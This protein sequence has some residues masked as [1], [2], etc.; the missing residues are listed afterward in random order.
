MFESLYL[1]P[2]Y[3]PDWPDEAGMIPIVS[4]RLFVLYFVRSQFTMINMI[5]N[6]FLIDCSVTV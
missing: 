4:Q 1:A 6:A 2:D 5:L 3:T